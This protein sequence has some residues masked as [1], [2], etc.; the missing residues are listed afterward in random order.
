LVGIVGLILN[1]L[2]N[3]SGDNVIPRVDDVKYSEKKIY[4]FAHVFNT[5][6]MYSVRFYLIY[7]GYFIM[8]CNDVM[9]AYNV[10]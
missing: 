2:N 5:I 1:F 3:K 4:P 10:R 7:K 8:Y 6:S 9:Y